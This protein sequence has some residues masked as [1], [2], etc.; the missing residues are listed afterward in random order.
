MILEK[1]ENLT[2]SPGDLDEAIAGFVVF[3]DAPGSP[4]DDTD[5]HGSAF[6]RIGA[7]QDGVINGAEACLKYAS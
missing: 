4:E 2:L 7:F 1:S 5:A 6:S 3:R